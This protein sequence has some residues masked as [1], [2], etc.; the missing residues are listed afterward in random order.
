MMKKLRFQV[1]A[2]CGL[3][4]L[5]SG[6]AWAQKPRAK[7]RPATAKPAAK[8][9]ATPPTATPTPEQQ[10][11]DVKGARVTT[12][13]T[14][15]PATPGPTLATVNGQPVTAADLGP[16]VLQALTTENQRI[17]EMRRESLEAQVNTLLLEAEA[18]KRKTSLDTLLDNEVSGKI[19]EPTEAEVQGLYDA[20]RARLEGQT[21]AQ[22]R[23]KIVAYL[24]QQ[25]EQK[26]TGEFA[27][28]L[29]AATPVKIVGD[30]N[31]PNLPANTILATAAGRTITAGKFEDKVK[32]LVYRMRHDLWNA[33]MNV[34]DLK[35][36]D[37]LLI[38]EAKKRG[39]TPDQLL[40]TE[41]SQKLQAPGEAEIKK[42]YDENKAQIGGRTLEQVRGDINDALMQ[43]RR[44][45]LESDLADQLR[46][47]GTIE[48]LLA[49]PAA[50]VLNIS[51]DDD[52]SHGPA[53]APVTV[54]VFTDF[55]CPACAQ[56]HP[57]VDAVAQEFGDKV[58]LVVRDFPLSMHPQARKA[59]E[60]ANAA[61][62]QGK[63]FDYINILYKNQSKLDIVSLKGYATAMGLDRTQ[64]D[65]ELDSGKY[66]PEVEK[67][68]ADGE[69]YGIQGT[70]TIFI[71]GVRLEQ[72][73]SE[74]IRAAINDA[75]KK[76]PKSE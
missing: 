45:Q 56:T 40:Q 33:T 6:G 55:Q 37:I 31:A 19:T 24:K 76:A 11:P 3:L 22:V 44:Q 30:P 34:L 53:N 16:D 48:I 41:I 43:Q 62:A 54:V 27:Q 67:D 65:A 42:V 71:N 9:P 68:M 12:P 61:N 39:V 32:P 26:L 57:V 21:L 23:P 75:L 74:A 51:A 73:S 46:K 70:P 64:F 36:N 52:P 60:A 1:A 63:F 47:G 50:P 10:L 14:T 49:E 20:N 35:I 5:S 7:A 28:R 17:A 2:W 66:A 58:R 4:L 13:G 38:A 8:T 25:Q 29:R 72:L 15:N 69:D 18:A 59:A